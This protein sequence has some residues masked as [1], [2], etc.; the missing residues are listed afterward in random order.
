MQTCAFPR[1]NTSEVIYLYF[2]VNFDIVQLL[3]G[4]IPG[5]TYN[6]SHAYKCA[7]SGYL[8]CAYFFVIMLFDIDEIIE[9]VRRWV[10]VGKFSRIENRRDGT[11][12]IIR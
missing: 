10:L 8:N 3:L 5:I 4:T 1:C 11:T 6:I 2:F 12:T 9:D 7:S